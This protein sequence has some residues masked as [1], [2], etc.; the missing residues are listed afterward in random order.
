MRTLKPS[1]LV[2]VA[3]Q[4][5]AFTKRIL[6]LMGQMHQHP[7]IFPL[8]NPTALAECTAEQAFAATEG[9]AVFASGSPNSPLLLPG[10][11]QVC[12]AMI[13]L[14]KVLLCTSGDAGVGLLC[15]IMW[16]QY[17]LCVCL[18]CSGVVDEKP[19]VLIQRTI[20]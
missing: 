3:A 11:R 14:V 2:G 10:A 6:T 13:R 12:H 17:C 19:L 1:V 15:S 20:C 7:F 8:S 4:P 5:G 16:G 18:T 9:R